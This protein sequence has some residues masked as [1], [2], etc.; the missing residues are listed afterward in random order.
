[1]LGALI[2]GWNDR[3]RYTVEADERRRMRFVDERRAAY[4]RFLTALAEW[5]PLRAEAWKLREE[6]D[7]AQDRQE[8][9]MRWAAARIQAEPSF[10]QLIAAHQEIH[11]L[12][13][14]P[15]RNAA[16][17]LFVEASRT[18]A[19]ARYREEFIT[20]VRID[21]GTDADPREAVSELIASGALGPGGQS[22]SD[23]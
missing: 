7:H 8:A 4:V 21:L 19:V 9:E 16:T 13:P 2:Q 22:K 11:V 23:D 5:E 10:Q 18:R 12:A 14:K 15:V 1:M 17:L 20:A 3:R 6:A